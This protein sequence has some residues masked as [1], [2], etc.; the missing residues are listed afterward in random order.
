MNSASEPDPLFG[1]VGERGGE[2]S[3]MA[4][5]MGLEKLPAEACGQIEGFLLDV[6]DTDERM[7]PTQS[8]LGP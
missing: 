6:G 2:L 7:R 1:G 5:D 4:H 3:Q 8:K